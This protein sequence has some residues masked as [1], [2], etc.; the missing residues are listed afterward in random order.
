MYI[1][2]KLASGA[3]VVV[4]L[5]VLAHGGVGARA[6]AEVVHKRNQ[7]G[8]FAVGNAGSPVVDTVFV[9]NQILTQQI[10]SL[11]FSDRCVDVRTVVSMTRV[12][13]ADSPHALVVNSENG[14]QNE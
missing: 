3:L 1:L 8:E 2:A 4:G 13:I 14:L 7:S 11:V 6:T 5:H 9:S 12:S 10:T